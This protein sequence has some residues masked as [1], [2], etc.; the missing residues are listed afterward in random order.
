MPRPL[1]PR[2]PALPRPG[3]R[4]RCPAP[5]VPDPCCNSHYIALSPRSLSVLLEGPSGSKAQLAGRDP[6]ILIYFCNQRGAGG[7][8]ARHR[9][10]GALYGDHFGLFCFVFPY[11]VSL[12]EPRVTMTCEQHQR[13]S[14]DKDAAPTWPLLPVSAQAPP[15]LLRSSGVVHK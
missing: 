1:F 3:A 13:T 9:V 8:G 12:L 11:I 4:A 7:S 15:R 6:R 2:P 5:C 10:I 14:S